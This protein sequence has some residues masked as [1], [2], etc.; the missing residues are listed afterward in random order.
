MCRHLCTVGNTTYVETNTPR[1]HALMLDCY[2]S[3]A[4]ED[5]PENKTR[6]AEVLYECCYC[7]QCQNNC[8][9]SYRHPD[10]VMKA[11]AD[12]PDEVLNSCVLS[13]K[14]L[15][16]KTGEPYEKPRQFDGGQ[17]ITNKRD[18]DVILYIG[19][20]VRNNSQDIAKAAIDI[21]E[22][23][24]V[25][26]TLLKEESNPGLIAYQMGMPKQAKELARSEIEK[27]NALN[28]KKLVTLNP[29]DF[30]VFSGGINI[31]DVQGLKP[32]VIHITQVLV[33]LIKSERIKLKPAAGGVVSYHDS[34]QLGRFVG[35]YDSPRE[36]INAVPKINFKEL[37]WN[38]GEAG[39]CGAGG[40]LEYT[41]PKLA[42]Q[43]AEKRW[44]QIKDKGIETVVTDCP[45]CKSQLMRSPS[46]GVDVVTISEFLL[47]QI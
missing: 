18:A 25:N 22:K 11:R 5:T 16:G 36:V 30:R 21:L 32:E 27:I 23:A 37:Y 44:D 14:N 2:D 34:C 40:G 26:Y 45:N 42:D 29:S 47:K 33:D 43:I 3:D 28:S 20:Y 13:I 15:V 4:L 31:F 19:S 8:V 9:S 6:M 17:Q 1:G 41:N 38:K 39:C 35:D 10:A 24:G 12:M 7:G 46:P